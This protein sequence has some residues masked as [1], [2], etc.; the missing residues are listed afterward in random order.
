[1]QVRRTED[2]RSHAPANGR[3][4][5]SATGCEYLAA[6]VP[7]LKPDWSVELHPDMI[8]E[9]LVV[10]LPDDLSDPLGFTLA[11]R[12]DDAGFHLEEL[13]GDT[14]RNL[15]ERWLWPEVPRAVPI[16]P[17]W[18][19]TSRNKKSPQQAAGYWW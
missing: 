12:R 7:E 18:E 14:S 6:L 4:T 8:G 10:I 13:S 17:T 9:P 3:A 19:N 16:R 15:G 1:M 11:V 2:R 5:L